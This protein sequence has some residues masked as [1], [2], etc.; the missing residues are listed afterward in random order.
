M[1]N[2]R[3]YCFICEKEASA[4]KSIFYPLKC[5]LNQKYT[6][7]FSKQSARMICWNISI[8][9]ITQMRYRPSI[10]VQKKSQI[11]NIRYASY[12]FYV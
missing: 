10:I 1:Q 7:P 8:T 3:L 6:F 11:K 4:L 12:K 2:I 5:K 9:F